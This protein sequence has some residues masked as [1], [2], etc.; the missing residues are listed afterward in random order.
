MKII[1]I[2]K[3]DVRA[4]EPHQNGGEFGPFPVNQFADSDNG[5]RP[6][7]SFKSIYPISKGP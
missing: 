1:K 7:M 4:G 3:T 6:T 5:E 2:S